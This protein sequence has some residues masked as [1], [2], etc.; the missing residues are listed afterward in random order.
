M[1]RIKREDSLNK[2]RDLRLSLVIRQH[3]RWC[4]GVL[5]DARY[6]ERCVNTWSFLHGLHLLRYNFPR[7]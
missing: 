5:G 2:R 6:A 3:A 1:E 4:I 7:A